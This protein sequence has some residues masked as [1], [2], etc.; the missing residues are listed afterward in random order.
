[1]NEQSL[2]KKNV[3]FAY[4]CSSVDFIAP[5]RQDS[6]NLNKIKAHTFIAYRMM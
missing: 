3:W 4:Q 2:I 6:L 5:V 1:M